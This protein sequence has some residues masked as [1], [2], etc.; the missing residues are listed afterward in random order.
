MF[1]LVSLR[2]YK[3]L[4]RLSNKEIVT[5]RNIPDIQTERFSFKSILQAG[6]NRHHG[7]FMCSSM[8]YPGMLWEP[9]CRD[10]QLPVSSI[11]SK[12]LFE[13]VCPHYY[14]RA[15]FISPN[16]HFL[17]GQFSEVIFS[18]LAAIP[19]KTTIIFSGKCP[20]GKRSFGEISFGRGLFIGEISFREMTG[21]Q[22]N[23]LLQYVMWCSQYTDNFASTYFRESSHFRCFVYTYY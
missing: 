18:W 1:P 11:H 3:H 12:Y 8:Y 10:T 2:L 14:Y 16:G 17:E 7:Y 22:F 19:P 4:W 5:Q 6:G 21:H 20:F 15:V 9:V 23:F 13:I